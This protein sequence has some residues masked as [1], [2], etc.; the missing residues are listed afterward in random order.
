MWQTTG[1]IYPSPQAYRMRWE[2]KDVGGKVVF[3][4]N[5]EPD[6]IEVYRR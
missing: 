2:V 6:V 1:G 5:G 3:F 4:P